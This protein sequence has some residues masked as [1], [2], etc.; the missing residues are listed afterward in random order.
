[1]TSDYARERL[2]EAHRMEASTKKIGAI[3]E[4]C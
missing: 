4:T 2:F 3:T 1:M